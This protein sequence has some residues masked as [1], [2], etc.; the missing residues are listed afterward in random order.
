MTGIKGQVDIFE[1]ITAQEYDDQFAPLKSALGPGLVVDDGDEMGAFAVFSPDRLYRYLLARSWGG[2]RYAVWLML[3]PSTADA[4]KLDPTLR[5]CRG[6]A[7]RWGCGGMVIL[8]AFAYRATDPKVM[9]AQDDPVGGLTNDTTIHTVAKLMPD[10]L[11][12]VGWGVHGT[13]RGRDAGVAAEL[14]RAGVQAQ[15]L[16]YTKDGHPGH[17]LLVPYATTPIPWPPPAEVT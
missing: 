8:N 7:Q 15:T 9:K 16:L 17:P 4:F 13:H 5:K 12:T 10:A 3:N 1:A 11:W 14:A 6:F 2:G